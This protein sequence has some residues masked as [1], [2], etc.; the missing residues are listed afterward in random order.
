[1][2]VSIIS[3]C[4]YI[5]CFVGS[6]YSLSSI[7]FELFCNVR[8]PMKVQMLLLFL[9]LGLAYCSAQFLLQI[10]IFNGL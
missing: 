10:T 5:L 8:Q 1:M 7:K 9:S 4:V 2:S 3:L 6:F